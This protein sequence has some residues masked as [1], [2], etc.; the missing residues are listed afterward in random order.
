[1]SNLTFNVRFLQSLHTV[2]DRSKSNE[3]G[4]RGGGPIGVRC[5]FQSVGPKSVCCLAGGSTNTSLLRTDVCWSGG[6]LKTE[7]EIVWRWIEREIEKDREENSVLIWAKLCDF[8]NVVFARKQI[9]TR[10]GRGRGSNDVFRIE[11]GTRL[12]VRY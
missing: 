11:R 4:P 12:R 10:K 8:Q 3:F 5:A 2:F 1:M 7:R 6:W 9:H